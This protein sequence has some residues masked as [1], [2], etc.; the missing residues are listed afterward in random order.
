MK[1][2]RTETETETKQRESEINAKYSERKARGNL[3][4]SGP[5]VR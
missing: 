2:V 5:E 4:V 1:R 3:K